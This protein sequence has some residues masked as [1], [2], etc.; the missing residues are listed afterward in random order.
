MTS[1]LS[2]I[3]GRTAPP[4]PTP[5][6]AFDDPDLLDTLAALSPAALDH[7]PFGVIGLRSSGEV[8]AYNTYE[9]RYAGLEAAE[10]L[11]RNFFIE[12][13]PCTNNA[14]VRGRFSSAWRAGIALDEQ[15]LYTF[16]FRM[17]PRK[18]MLRLLARG[19]RG[20]LLVQ[21]L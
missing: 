18:V 16:A 14:M 1:A 19:A 9:Q 20:W 13:A 21:T 7:L 8:V 5:P 12:I 3:H 10:V 15:L 11:G 4:P 6:G 2:E 17:R